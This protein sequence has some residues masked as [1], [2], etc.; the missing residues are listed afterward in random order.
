M[1]R[2]IVGL[3]VL[4]VFGCW[5]SQ[6]PLSRA[7]DPAKGKE[8]REAKKALADEDFFRKATE[9][10]LAEVS[11]GRLAAQRAHRNEVKEFSQALVEDH[12]KS[13]NEYL[14]LAGKKRWEPA[15]QIDEKHQALAQKL[16]GLKGED[17]DKEFLQAMVH[18]HKEAV[19][20]YEAQAQ[21]A[22]D[23]DLKMLV[24]KNLPTIKKHLQMAQ[25]LSGEKGGENRNPNQK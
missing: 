6:N 13:L 14:A 24:T 12:S 15:R 23:E 20:M 2:R 3:T 10:D 11:M 7:E 9:I 16:A 19:A 17:F 5:L 22:R 1:V 18:G 8:N 21:G 25:Q 4:T